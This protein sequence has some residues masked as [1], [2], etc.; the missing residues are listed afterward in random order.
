MRRRRLPHVDEAVSVKTQSEKNPKTHYP[1]G[2]ISVTIYI[3]D[4]TRS[5]IKAEKIC[6]DANL[7][8]RVI[9]VPRS[10]SPKCG[11][12][13]EVEEDCELKVA[14]VLQQAGIEA[15]TVDRRD[16]TL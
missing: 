10:I 8:V 4:S 2:G 5:V 13:L 7:K 6:R 11:M 14:R 16:V 9:P 3:F 12:A 1:A 15:G